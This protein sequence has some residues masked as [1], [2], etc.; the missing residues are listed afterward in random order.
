MDHG[1]C[2]LGC[3]VFSLGYDARVHLD[4]VHSFSYEDVSQGTLHDMTEHYIIY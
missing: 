4:S 2:D 1:A 3:D